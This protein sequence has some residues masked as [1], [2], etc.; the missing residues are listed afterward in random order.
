[1]RAIKPLQVKLS[2][3]DVVSET[4]QLPLGPAVRRRD[5]LLHT[6]LISHWLNEN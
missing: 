6:T 1:M 5:I 3:G 2:I 4:C